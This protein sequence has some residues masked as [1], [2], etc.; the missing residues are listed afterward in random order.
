MIK[1]KSLA[2]L[3]VLLI[4]VALLAASSASAA[5][6]V[7][8][9]EHYKTITAS[10]AK[11]TSQVASGGAYTHIPLRRPHATTEGG[12]ADT[13]HAQYKINVPQAGS[14]VFWGR[15]HWYDG[16]GNSFFLKLDNKPATVFG[17]DGTYQRWHWVKGIRVSLTA[18]AHTITIQNREDGAK[19]D[20]F[21][22]TTSSRYVPV[23]PEKETTQYIISSQ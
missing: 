11:A 20:Q 17:N 13:G 8:E 5:K 23:R 7:I 22:L 2:T 1:T 6:I 4:V 3:M 19:L 14:Y 16:C 18:G 10:M 21:M 12:P 9:A 15:A